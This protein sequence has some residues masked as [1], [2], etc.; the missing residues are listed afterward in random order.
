MLF[1]TNVMLISGTNLCNI[2]EY[3]CFDGLQ[4]IPMERFCD[5]I[6]HCRDGSDESLLEMVEGGVS[7]NCGT[8][9]LSVVPCWQSSENCARIYSVTMQNAIIFCSI[10]YRRD[11]YCFIV[12]KNA[13]WDKERIK[14][15]YRSHVFSWDIFINHPMSNSS[16]PSAITNKSRHVLNRRLQNTPKLFLLV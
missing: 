4:C 15:K 13:F 7:H 11:F 14:S 12:S 2:D 5:G 1:L 6:K 10:I 8:Y 9:F 16:H 3:N